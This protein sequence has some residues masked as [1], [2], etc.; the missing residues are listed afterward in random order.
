MYVFMATSCFSNGL[1]LLWFV[2]REEKR[3]QSNGGAPL[4]YRNLPFIDS[5]G[6]FSKEPSLEKQSASCVSATPSSC[7]NNTVSVS[8]LAAAAIASLG[9]KNSGREGPGCTSTLPSSKHRSSCIVSGNGNNTNN[10]NGH[11]NSSSNLSGSSTLP[12]HGKSNGNFKNLR[13]SIFTDESP[14][15]AQPLVVIR[16]RPDE[17]GRFGFNVKVSATMQ[18]ANLAFSAIPRSLVNEF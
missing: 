18:Q 14:T 4:S 16:M 10:N 12:S 8:S 2:C 7:S 15:Q 6:S 3:I 11:S 13:L 1:V 9:S 5:N 17:Q